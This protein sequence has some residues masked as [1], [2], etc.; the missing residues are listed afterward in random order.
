MKKNINI[1]DDEK[2][3]R[4]EVITDIIFFLICIFFPLGT[5]TKKKK[6]FWNFF[7]KNISFLFCK[8][9]FRN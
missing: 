9:L 2:Q 1:V 8:I 4:T 7:I 6:H 5:K 3:W